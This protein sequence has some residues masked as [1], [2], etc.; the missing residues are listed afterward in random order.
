V[1]MGIASLGIASTSAVGVAG[2]LYAML[3]HGIVISLLFLI[4]GAVDE[5]YGTL[6]I[7]RLKGVAKNIPF[8]AYSFV[9]GVFALV[10]IPL[11]S[12]FI[13]DLLVF[14][15]A[16]GAY[17]IGGITPL[18]AVLIIGAFLF[19]VIERVFFSASKAIEP[20]SNPGLGIKLAIAFLSASAVLLGTVPSLLLS[21]FAV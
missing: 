21:P 12:G 20:H 18:A 14:I 6:L 17:S 7:E 3:S 5:A 2:G 10:G 1:D 13:G 4:A 11:T 8:L 15:G 9:F 16:F 19:L